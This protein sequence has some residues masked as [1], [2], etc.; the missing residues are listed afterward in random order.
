MQNTVH[1][2]IHFISQVTNKHDKAEGTDTLCY[3]PLKAYKWTKSLSRGSPKM[4]TEEIKL[5]DKKIKFS[6]AKK[7]RL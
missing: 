7:D 6:D 4:L 2:F 3:T 1:S 5:P